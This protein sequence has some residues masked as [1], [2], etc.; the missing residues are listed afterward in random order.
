MPP[1]FVPYIYSHEEVKRLLEATNSRKHN[2]LSAITCRT[3]LLLLY[4]A[5]LRIS[6]AIGLDLADEVIFQY[7]QQM[8]SSFFH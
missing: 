4:G 5:G 1:R 2:N 8:N 7:V 6:E 3:L